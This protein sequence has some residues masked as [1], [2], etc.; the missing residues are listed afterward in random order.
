MAPAP[1][2]SISSAHFL[3]PLCSGL[4]LL[5]LLCTLCTF[6]KRRRKK[7]RTIRNLCP[8]GVA[9]VDVSLLRQTQLRS[10]SKSDTKLHEIQRPR[11]G[12]PHLRP[13]SMDPMY[14]PVRWK[15]PCD[16]TGNDTT[17]CNLSFDPQPPPC[18]LY[19][20]VNLGSELGSPAVASHLHCGALEEY[21]FV[22][23][24]KKGGHRGEQDHN[25][26]QNLEFS[27]PSDPSLVDRPDG[28]KLEEMYSKVCKKKRATPAEIQKGAADSK[29][30]A[31]ENP[32]AQ[33][34]TSTENTAP[35]GIPSL[36]QEEN[37]YESICEMSSR[38]QGLLRQEGEVVIT[39]L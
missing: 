10:L 17:Y 9:L 6:C 30:Q 31:A 29:L 23:K 26:D 7:K 37:F 32:S 21:A 39:E 22:R 2:Q 1:V 36:Q 12:D 14:P 18:A 11:Q 28:Q 27:P 5:L 8:S 19:E 15:I 16:P 4:G 24:V 25:R 35:K 13:V 33:R 3:P 38:V 20:S 34:C